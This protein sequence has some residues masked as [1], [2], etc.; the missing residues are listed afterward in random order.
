MNLKIEKLIKLHHDQ[1]RMIMNGKRSFLPLNVLTMFDQNEK[2]RCKL[3]I[4]ND[5]LSLSV[6]ALGFKPKTF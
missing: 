4:Y 1:V 3:L 5:L 2:S 6:T